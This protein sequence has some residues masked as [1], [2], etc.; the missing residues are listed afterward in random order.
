MITFQT[1]FSVYFDTVKDMQTFH[2]ALMRIQA[3]PL[4]VNLST[5]SE[6]E[7][8]TVNYIADLTR[9]GSFFELEDPSYVNHFFSI[10]D[11]IKSRRQRAGFQKAEFPKNELAIWNEL[12]SLLPRELE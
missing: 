2:R 4:S 3:N 7:L 1:K 5:L 8:S 10:I 6:E 11:K 12:D 9:N